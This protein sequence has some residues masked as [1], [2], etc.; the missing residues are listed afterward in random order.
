MKASYY[1]KQ[2]IADLVK[3]RHGTSCFFAPVFCGSN[4][5]FITVIWVA[6]EA[7]K[8]AS[9]LHSD[10]KLNCDVRYDNTTVPRKLP[11]FGT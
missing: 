11:P 4:S 7:N 8:S 10:V 2:Q 3:L 9:W 1:D 5:N 6:C